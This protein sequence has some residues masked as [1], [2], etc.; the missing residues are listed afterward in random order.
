MTRPSLPSVESQIERVLGE[1]TAAS[2]GRDAI[3]RVSGPPTAGKSVFLTT[4][5][6]RLSDTGFIP[7]LL[8]P[9]WRASDAGAAV[10][11]DLAAAL[12]DAGV[13]QPLAVISDAGVDWETKLA[14]VRQ[15]LERDCDR[16]VLLVDEPDL[17]RMPAAYDDSPFVRHAREVADMLVEGVPCRRVVTGRGDGMTGGRLLHLA[18]RSDPRPWLQ[19][20]AQ[21][22]G[23][24]EAAAALWD[25]GGDELARLSP[26]Q[27]RLLVALVKLHGPTEVRR[28]LAGGESRREISR[29]LAD[30]LEERSDLSPLKEIWACLSLERG[31]FDAELPKEFGEAQ[32]PA[33]LRSIL[34][35]CLLYQH[36]DRWT[37]HDTLRLDVIER[38]WLSEERRRQI[39]RQLA[40][41]HHRRFESLREHP[42]RYRLALFHEFEAFHHYGEAGDMDSALGLRCWFVDQL[43]ALGRILSR[44]FRNYSGAV[45]VFRR[46]LDHLPEDPYAN[47]YLAW[48]LD[49]Q[50]LEPMEVESRYRKALDAEPWNVWWHG[51]YINFLI[52]RG[53]TKDARH[54]W[55][56]AC[57]AL[58]LP[59]PHADPW[60]YENLHMW[61][62]RLLI[63]RGQLDFAEAVMRQIPARTIRDHPG[64]A[65]LFR[66]LRTLLEVRRTGTVFPLGIPSERWWDGPHLLHT[67]LPDQGLELKWWLPGRVD[68]VEEGRL[69]LF[70][71]YP[72]GSGHRYGHME[73]TFAE[74]DSQCMDQV[75]ARDLTPGRFLE[76]GGY[77]A[78]TAGQ[79]KKYIRVHPARYDEDLD[80]P[81]LWPNPVRYL[82]RWNDAVF[83]DGSYGR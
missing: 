26:L 52:T 31:S 29:W 10:L 51:R 43:N 61:V 76:I 20:E 16:Y 37:L 3:W 18:P 68:A 21:W 81:P 45:T 72:N 6:E 48:N 4:L 55:D 80:L 25:L 47:H 13:P 67:R 19:D 15:A 41:F 49:V 46:V 56:D 30:T 11:L 60:V 36:G 65:A 35:R 50:G 8:S 33:E 5:A 63:H 24:S 12:S 62:A 22:D 40:R 64:L 70:V 34:W 75:R 59:D 32:L 77:A 14:A 23:L 17:A 38:Q 71:A 66:R 69:S 7:V 54:A 1:V 9:A 82:R 57:D 28:R 42:E 44:D 53:R 73:M 2:P 58:G 83:R 74:F 78:A 39:H 27:N 79:E